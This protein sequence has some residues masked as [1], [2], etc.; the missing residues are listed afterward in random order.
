MSLYRQLL[1]LEQTLIFLVDD[2]ET[3][4][5]LWQALARARETVLQASADTPEPGHVEQHLQESLARREQQVRTST[6]V[7]QEIANAP[8]LDE[9]YRRVV[10][11]VKERFGY[12]HVQLF[13]ANRAGD[14][15]MPV[16]GSGAVG[17]KLF[18]QGY[19]V[20]WG[21]GIVGRAGASGQ[22]TLAADVAED[23]SWIH[24]PL[25]PDTK[26]ELAV[27]IKLRRWE[28]GVAR[29]EVVGVLDV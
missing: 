20:A 25:L 10:T 13:L 16:A 6:E 18:D 15:L 14:K 19:F 26:G 29:D 22:A 17:Q 8:A 7:A 4:A 9:L 11:L 24:D 2:V 21:E 3:A 1:A 5:F 28:A 23:P 12:Y 27:P